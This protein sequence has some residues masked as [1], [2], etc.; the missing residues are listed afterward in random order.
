MA[1]GHSSKT[2]LR[3]SGGT[4][5]GP[6][7][8]S[9]GKLRAGLIGLGMRRGDRVAILSDNSPEWVVVDQAVLGL[10]AIVVP[11]YT[12]SGIEETAHVIS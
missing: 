10:G 7:W 3:K 5:H 12:T 11:L 9:A 6:R 4:I 1:R 8:R 2:S